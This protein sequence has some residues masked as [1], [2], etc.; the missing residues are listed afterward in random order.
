MEILLYLLLPF[1]WIYMFLTWLWRELKA[2][3]YWL[4]GSEAE[5]GQLTASRLKNG[6]TH[7]PPPA[8]KQ[9]T[10]ITGPDVVKQEPG[11]MDA[12]QRMIPYIM[13]EP[14]PEERQ[15]PKKELLEPLPEIIFD[16]PEKPDRKKKDRGSR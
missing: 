1:V 13:P 4:C 9:Q 3:F 12:R 16:L 11:G 10:A 14:G 8:E 7:E 5:P 6:S 15:E 2:L